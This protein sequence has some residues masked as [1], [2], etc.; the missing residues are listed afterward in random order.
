MKNRMLEKGQQRIRSQTK[1]IAMLA[2][3]NPKLELVQ[4]LFYQG[5]QIP[6]TKHMN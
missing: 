6:F 5:I 3:V 1:L 4:T 2:D